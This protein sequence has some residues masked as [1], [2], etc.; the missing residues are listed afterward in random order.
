MLGT[1]NNEQPEIDIQVSGMT[2]TPITVNGIIDSGFNGY[3]TLPYSIAFPLGLILVG[4]ESNTIADGSASSHLVCMGM[5]CIDG[6]CIETSIDIQ[7]AADII[8]IGTKLLKEFG[9]TFKLDAMNGIVELSD[10]VQI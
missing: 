9:K 5:V 3:L 1:F 4:I 2:K 8:L 6:K 7:P 10:S